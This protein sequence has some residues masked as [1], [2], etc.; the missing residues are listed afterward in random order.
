MIMIEAFGIG[1]DRCD[2]VFGVAELTDTAS[3]A[4]GSSSAF[5]SWIADAMMED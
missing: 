5:S 4:S 3:A 2:A 1:R